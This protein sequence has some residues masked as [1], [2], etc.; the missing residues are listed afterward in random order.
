MALHVPAQPLR[1]G[2]QIVMTDACGCELPFRVASMT[3]WS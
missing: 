1:L 3:E 2:Q